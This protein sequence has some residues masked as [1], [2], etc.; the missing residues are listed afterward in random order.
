MKIKKTTES[1][2]GE[3]IYELTIDKIVERVIEYTHSEINKRIDR[4]AVKLSNIDKQIT[5]LN[6]QKSKIVKESEE[7]TE[8]KAEIK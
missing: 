2:D 8:A 4:L 1:R 7:L 5:E 3:S 6:R